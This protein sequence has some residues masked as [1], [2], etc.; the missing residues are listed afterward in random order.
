MTTAV[1]EVH[2][3]RDVAQAPI[4]VQAPREPIFVSAGNAELFAATPTEAVSAH[5]DP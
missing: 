5:L 1:P 3:S 4:A 2:V